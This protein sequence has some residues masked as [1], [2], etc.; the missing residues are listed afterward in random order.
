[1]EM[2]LEILTA[3]RNLELIWYGMHVLCLHQGDATPALA[4]IEMR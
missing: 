4:Y 3:Q 2:L 1:M